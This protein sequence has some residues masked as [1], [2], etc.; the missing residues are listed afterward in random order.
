MQSSDRFFRPGMQIRTRRCLRARRYAKR[1][2][3]A[4]G[5]DEVATVN[6]VGHLSAIYALIFEALKGSIMLRSLA[7][8]GLVALALSLANLTSAPANSASAQPA[9][10]VT[11]APPHVNAPASDMD[12][13]F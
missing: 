8:A 10:S 5:G 1:R 13:L 4:A 11:E 12:A 2:A 3:D 9:G 6:C 7:R